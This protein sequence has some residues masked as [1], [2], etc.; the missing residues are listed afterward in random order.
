MSAKKEKKTNKGKAGKGKK[1]GDAGD[2]DDF[3]RALLKAP[4]KQWVDIKDDRGAWFEGRVRASD[5]P[6]KLIE[7][8]YHGLGKDS[9]Q[10][11]DVDHVAP[12]HTHTNAWRDKIE[13]GHNIVVEV[14]FGDGNEG[15]EHVK[16]L[17]V[18]SERMVRYNHPIHGPKTEPLLH[19]QIMDTQSYERYNR[20]TPVQYVPSVLMKQ[21][22][23]EGEGKERGATAILKP[24]LRKDG[25]DGAFGDEGF[26][27]FIALLDG[28]P[29]DIDATLRKDF[30][31][32]L[33]LTDSGPLRHALD[34][35]SVAISEP[36]KV[37]T[38]LHNLLLEMKSVEATGGVAPLVGGGAGGGGEGYDMDAPM[39]TDQEMAIVKSN[40]SL[41]KSVLNGNEDALESARN[42]HCQ[43]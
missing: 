14:E 30:V 8:S 37:V 33:K 23:A 13:K 9:K 42:G 1:G 2:G 43:V 11:C 10:W 16:V 25:E 38:R 20:V 15:Y 39:L 35:L 4:N 3:F 12:H 31:T 26:D 6:K 19:D 41:L 32:V 36:S 28:A 17:E 7:C 24:F 29:F 40:V 18:T 34:E 22:R 5:R 27:K 21:Y